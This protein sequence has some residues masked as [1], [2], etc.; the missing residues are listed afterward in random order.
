MIK[1]KNIENVSN[2]APFNKST[3]EILRNFIFFLHIT[4]LNIF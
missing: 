3:A 2:V 1:N 4:K